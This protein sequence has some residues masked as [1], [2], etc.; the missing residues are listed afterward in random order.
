MMGGV[1][2]EIPTALKGGRVGQRCPQRAAN[3]ATQTQLKS[4]HASPNRHAAAR[5][6]QRCP[7]CPGAS[8]TFE[9]LSEYFVN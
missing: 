1:L 5:W 3:V 7:T 8:G 6:G 2:F 9:R 4:S